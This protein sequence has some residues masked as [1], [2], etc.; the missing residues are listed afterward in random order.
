[1]K[2]LS[3]LNDAV[4]KFEPDNS[5][6]AEDANLQK[7]L[8]SF[9]AVYVDTIS[10][11]LADLARESALSS[12][13]PIS[14]SSLQAY[15]K[16]ASKRY[17]DAMVEYDQAVN[18]EMLR[19][20]SLTQFSLNDDR[21]KGKFRSYGIQMRFEFQ[22]RLG[23][24]SFS[25]VD[26]VQEVS[27]GQLY[28]CKKVD[29]D[30]DSSTSPGELEEVAREEV[31]VMRRLRQQHIASVLIGQREENHYNIFMM[32]VAHCNLRQ[33][34]EHCTD[35]NYKSAEINPIFQ[36]FGC[37]LGAL[38]HAHK[39]SIKHRDIKPSNI[40]IKDK[41]PY[42]AD[43]GLAKDFSG[44]E[45]SF[46][47]A[48]LVEGTP[49]YFAP[50]YQPGERYGRSA[51]IFGLGCVFSEMLTVANYKSLTDFKNWRRPA[52]APHGSFAFRDSLSRVRD[53]LRRFDENRLN[54]VLVHQ[55]LGMLHQDPEQRPT[56]QDGVNYLSRH[57]ALSCAVC[58]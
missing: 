27:T 52:Q 38:N 37:I 49:Q 5:P 3:I 53:W 10:S 48:F 42:L 15:V 23:R 47:E 35:V 40:L 20:K 11:V 43:F 46:S 32:P 13:S 51:D 2:S 33:Y 28:A 44:A 6:F 16:E 30:F 8:Q 1:M 58:R 36:W 4:P 29:L 25:Q 41:T 54:D 9:F 34:L 26:E 31:K 39:L 21:Q 7:P 57:Q 56:A 50:E 17:E 18:E 22:R 45:S 24:G 12:Q 14:E 55:T 19:R